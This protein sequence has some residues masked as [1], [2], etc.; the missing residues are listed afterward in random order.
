MK[1]LLYIFLAV[2]IIFS[3]CEKEEENT[4]TLVAPTL[5][6]GCTDATA[7]NYNSSA[8][9]DDDSCIYPP[10]SIVGYWNS[11]EWNIIQNVGYWTSYPNGQKVITY[12]QSQ[13]NNFWLDLIFATNGDA[14]GVD[15]DGYVMPSD[16]IINGNILLMD[17]TNFTISTLNSSYLTLELFQSD[18]N[19]SFSNP[20]NDTIYFT[21]RI[22]SFKFE[23]NTN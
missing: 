8:T 22:E 12:T 16:W 5:V 21:D 14:G 17:G 7:T 4:P 13:T 9:N 18:T 1:K 10:V 19:T 20:I 3:A 2:S 6:N 15:E 23:R 11:F